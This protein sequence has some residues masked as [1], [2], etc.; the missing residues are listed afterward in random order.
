MVGI[1][2]LTQKFERVVISKWGTEDD[3]IVEN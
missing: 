1:R 3:A 2:K